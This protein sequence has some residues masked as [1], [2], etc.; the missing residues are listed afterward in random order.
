[1]WGANEVSRMR[2]CIHDHYM[3][4]QDLPQAIQPQWVYV[5]IGSDR[6]LHKYP[7]VELSSAV[8]QHGRYSDSELCCA[9]SWVYQ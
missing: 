9:C 2:R 1:M 8:N 5:D 4:S 3:I 6:R 7:E